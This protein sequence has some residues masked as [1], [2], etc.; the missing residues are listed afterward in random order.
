MGRWSS[1]AR[2][3]CWKRQDAQRKYRSENSGGGCNT[4]HQLPLGTNAR[5]RQERTT[6]KTYHALRLSNVR[7]DVLVEVEQVWGTCSN[8]HVQ[9]TAG[10][11]EKFEHF[12]TTTYTMC[13][14]PIIG[15]HS[16]RKTLLQR[17]YQEPNGFEW[18]LT[19]ETGALNLA[20]AILWDTLGGKPEHRISKRFALDVIQQL[21]NDDWSMTEHEVQKWVSAQTRRYDL[22]FS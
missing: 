18:G 2:T 3:A 9:V 22:T 19:A 8:C 5:T 15:E 7:G 4:D 10:L 14:A 17:T 1:S 12:N 11:H 20:I 6:M 13:H 16:I 21:P